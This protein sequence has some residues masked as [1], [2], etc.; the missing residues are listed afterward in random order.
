MI[1][2]LL[3]KTYMVSKPCTLFSISFFLLMMSYKSAM[4]GTQRNPADSS[5]TSETIQPN[6][7]ILPNPTFVSADYYP[8]N[9]APYLM[10]T[11]LNG[12]N[13]LEWAQFVKLVID[14]RG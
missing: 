1:I 13:Y 6:P 2:L 10:A 5:G 8:Q 4:T 14:G 9:S 7:T 11:K 3:K 12:H